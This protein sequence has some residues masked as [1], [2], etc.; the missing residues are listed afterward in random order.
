[1]LNEYACP[2]CGYDELE[3][4][5]YDSYGCP[6]FDICPS[7]GTQFGYDDVSTKHKTLR[8]RWVANGMKWS[9]TSLEKPSKWSPNEQLAK[10]KK[11]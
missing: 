7:C 2:V 1:M 4:P 11:N 6:S 9:S 5:A 8:E 10:L 3:E